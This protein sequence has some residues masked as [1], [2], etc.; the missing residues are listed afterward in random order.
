[1]I[2]K[3]E[4]TLVLSLLCARR[5]QRLRSR[6]PQAAKSPARD[7]RAHPLPCRANMQ[8][9]RAEVVAPYGGCGRVGRVPARDARAQTLRL[10][11][12]IRTRKREI[13]RSTLFRSE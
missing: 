4:R 3:R 8:G 6:R 12:R 11:R 2:R 10:S 9:W 13:L 1:M 5:A 7:A